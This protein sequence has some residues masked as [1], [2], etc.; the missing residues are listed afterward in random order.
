MQTLFAAKLGQ[1]PPQDWPGLALTAGCHQARQTALRDCRRVAVHCRPGESV[2]VH[3]HALH[4]VA[5][6]GQQAAAGPDGRMICCFR[7][8][9][10]HKQAW[11]RAP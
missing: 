9:L 2:V 11:L 5:P 8:E 10:Q 3:R 7:P 1:L 4:G 6:W